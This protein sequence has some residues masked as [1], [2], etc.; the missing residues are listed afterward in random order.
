MDIWAICS[1]RFVFSGMCS[2]LTC[3]FFY[4]G[5]AFN[6]LCSNCGMQNSEVVMQ[7]DCTS[8]RTGGKTSSSVNLSKLYP[9]CLNTLAGLIPIRPGLLSNVTDRF[10]PDDRITVNEQG[11]LTC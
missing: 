7:C 11:W 4:R 2:L 10:L 3:L 5:N 9:R 1:L 8:V 6:L